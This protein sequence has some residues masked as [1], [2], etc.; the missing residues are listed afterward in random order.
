M[1][2]FT[3]GGDST[4]LIQAL[5]E[6]NKALQPLTGNAVTLAALSLSLH[7]AV[8]TVAGLPAAGS[9]LGEQRYVSNGRANGSQGAGTGTG[10]PVF[11]SGTAWCAIWSGVQVLA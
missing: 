6:I 9:F 3:G 10:C 1:S 4:R 2:G 5:Q 11:W 8:S 7:P